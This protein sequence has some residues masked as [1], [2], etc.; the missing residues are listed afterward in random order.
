MIYTE[1]ACS[2]YI[3]VYVCMCV[4]VILAVIVGVICAFLVGLLCG[5]ALMVAI[6][7]AY[8]KCNGVTH[9]P[10]SLQNSPTGLTASPY[11]LPPSSSSQPTPLGPLY[12]D[13]EL[14][15]STKDTVEFKHNVAYGYFK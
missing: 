9:R 12:E 6:P 4:C 3:C 1:C 11:S 8:I 10:S 2:W 15:T 13:I 7:I 5:V 14:S